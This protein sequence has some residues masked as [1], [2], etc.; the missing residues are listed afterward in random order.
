[1]VHESAMARMERTVRR[2]WILLIILAVFLVGSNALW[3]VYESQF[4]E[5][6]TSV[7]MDNENGYNSYIGNDGDI[8]N[9]TNKGDNQK[10]RP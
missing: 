6:T 5:A 7:E 1:M 2:L 8:Y 4:E 10:P 3:I 9:G